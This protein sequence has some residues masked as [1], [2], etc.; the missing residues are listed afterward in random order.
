MSASGFVGGK[1][2]LKGGDSLKGG[3]KKKKKKASS[4]T[5]LALTGS[6]GAGEGQQQKA[7]EPVK[8]KDGYMLPT[9]ASDADRRTEAEKR[10]QER[11]KKLEE[12]RLLKQAAKGYRDRVKDF[13]EHLASLSEHHDIPKGLFFKKIAALALIF[14]GGTINY[15]ILQSLRDAIIVTSC[16]AEALPFISAFGVLPASLIFFMYY[17]RLVSTM[18]S[19]AVFYFSLAP[20]VIF[21]GVFAAVATNWSYTLFFI[22]AELW[23][24]V[25]IS[26]LFWSL[27]D[28][29]CTVDEA[30][31]VYPKARLG[32][33][34]NFGLI[35][36]GAF[37][38]YVNEVLA[39][40]N[41]VLSL[42]A[43]V[44]GAVLPYVTPHAGPAGK[45]KKKKMEGEKKNTM[46]LLTS[47]SRILNLTVLVMGYGIAHKLFGFVWKGQMKVLYPSTAEYTTVMGD[48]A[49]YTGATTIGLMLI[50]KYVFQFLG[51]RGA[52]LVT[53]V[54][55]LLSGAV[56]FAGSLY[57]PGSVAAG[58]QLAMLLALGPA[59]GIVAQVFGRAAKYSLFDPSKEMVFITMDKEEKEKGKAAVD[60][61]GNQIGKSGGSWV[62]QGALIAFGSMS[63][64]LPFTALFYIAVCLVWLK[65][66]LDL[67]KTMDGAEE[68]KKVLA[69]I[70]STPLLEAPAPA[71]LILPAFASQSGSAVAVGAEGVLSPEKKAT[72]DQEVKASM[73]SHF[74]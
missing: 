38:R 15:T 17:E 12:E 11:L 28:D 4:G 50:S 71:K 48:V 16:G 34:A 32:I 70:D 20:M 66:T 5:E 68:E 39:K 19:K 35:A 60:I 53:P 23:G 24:S 26:L 74:D 65:S 21:Y 63:G 55:I 18:D 59:A 46:E 45:K 44:D 73:Q 27:A 31:D 52:A 9:P 37:T 30:K 1:L 67:A 7:A 22:L 54:V 56:F 72:L 33:L 49:S 62:M 3:V 61:L 25:A 41:E 47:S 14:L 8:T 36:A 43:Y 58:S 40:N 2:K 10:H 69:S 6:E 51:W 42:Q 13:N 64:A 57:P 29:V